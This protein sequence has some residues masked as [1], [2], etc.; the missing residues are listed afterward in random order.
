MLIAVQ[1]D[2]STNQVTGA[3]IAAGGEAVAPQSS[4]HASFWR[5]AKQDDWAVDLEAGSFTFRFFGE[6]KLVTL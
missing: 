5:F 3:I 4:T 1:T 6:I 2:C